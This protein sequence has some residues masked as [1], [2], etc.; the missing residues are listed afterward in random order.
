MGRCTTCD[1]VARR[2]AGAA[3]PWDSILRTPHWDVVHAFGTSLEGWIV[4]VARRHLPA[5]ADLSPEEA[6][7]L[8]PLVQRVSAAL[9][10]VVQC[11]KTYVVQFAEA[12][13]HRH[14]HVHVIP[15]ATDMPHDQLGPRVF[16][17]LGVSE[18]HCVPEARMDELASQLAPRLA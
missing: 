7:E 9:H 11:E 13:Q 5:V 8:G 18:E 6:A 4:L 17:L 15:R 1:L 12:E 10:E 16:S 2:D 3:P 14:V